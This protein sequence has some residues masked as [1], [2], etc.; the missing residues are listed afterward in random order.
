LEVN[1]AVVEKTDLG[2]PPVE[3]P[4]SLEKETYDEANSIARFKIYCYSLFLSGSVG[5][6]ISS[7]ILF[8]GAHFVSI[9]PHFMAF[10]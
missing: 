8:V 10:T 9:Y 6:L 1:A 3:G 4:F 2:P 7:I 5:W